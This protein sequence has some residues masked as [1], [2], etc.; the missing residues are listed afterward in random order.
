MATRS[1]TKEALQPRKPLKVLN[2]ET[3]TVIKKQD[4]VRLQQADN[5]IK[6]FESMTEVKWKGEQELSFEKKRQI[7]YCLYK[8]PTVNKNQMVRQVYRKFSDKELLNLHTVL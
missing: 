1:Q 7:L 8:N 4:L 2:Q 6:K 5:S 3:D